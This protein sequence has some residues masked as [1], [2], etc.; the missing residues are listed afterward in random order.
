MIIRIE[1]D[2]GY[3]VEKKVSDGIKVNDIYRELAMLLIGYGFHPDNVKELFREDEQV[4]NTK[5]TRIDDKFTNRFMIKLMIVKWDNIQKCVLSVFSGCI[6][7][8]L[9]QINV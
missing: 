6:K 2:D 5:E 7:C 4:D 9:P 8:V 1:S 3:Y